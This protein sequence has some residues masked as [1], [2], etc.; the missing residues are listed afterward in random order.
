MSFTKDLNPNQREAVENFDGPS[1]ILSGAGSGKT[2]VL[3]YRIANMIE[4]GVRPWN[5]LAVTFTNKAAKEM[6]ERLEKLIGTH[7]RD[8]WAGTFHSIFARILRK[9]GHLL[10]YNRNFNIYDTTDAKAIVKSIITERL[11][12]DL[13]KFH[14]NPVYSQISKAKNSLLTPS[15]YEESMPSNFF[16]R[17]V[18]DVYNFYQKQLQLN[19]AMDFD[20]LISLP[21][22][23][24]ESNPQVLEAYQNK[25]HYILVD[26][27]QDTNHA[28]YKL[29]NM[30]ADAHRNLCVIGDDDQSIYSFRGATIENILNFEKDYAEA[31]VFKLEQNYRSTK[32]ILKAAADVVKN[33]FERKEKEIW[34]D[35]DD[36]E[37]ISLIEAYD[38]RDEARRI[39]SSIT[40]EISANRRTLNEFALLYRTN[41]QSRVLEEAL[42]KNGLKYKIFG[43][44]KFYD[45]KEIKD[46]LAYL[47]VLVNPQDSQNLK[48]IIN[49]PSRKIG[50]TT[51]EKLEGYSVSQ[52]MTLFEVCGIVEKLG[53]L[54]SRSINPIKK[55]HYEISELISLQQQNLPLNELVRNV[56]EKFGLL[57][58]YEDEASDE[59][60]VK[61][62]NVREL[63]GGIDEF[64]SER[65]DNSLTVFLEEVSLITDLDKD[66]PNSEA[67]TLMT[68]HSAKGLEFPT[69]FVSGLEDG[70][71]PIIDLYENEEKGIEE[72]GRLFYVAVTRA[73]EKLYVSFA[74]YRRR[75][76]GYGESTVKSRFLNE[77]SEDLMDGNVKSVK[78]YYSS[79]GDF[80]GEPKPKQNASVPQY[81]KKY[82]SPFSS[83]K[84]SQ[85]YT[86]GMDVKHEIF[87]K[88]R[89]V[90][91]SGSGGES[92]ISISFD[93]VGVKKLV[94]RFAKL[95][96]V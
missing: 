2:R 94:Q 52:E 89:I 78:N 36:G 39:L 77:I 58:I 31:Q 35:N 7:A 88:G 90:E 33:N 48:R 85:T 30:L 6:V 80:Y 50:K 65:E 82:S 81:E 92:K 15:D 32:N 12:L 67:I 23:L 4:K 84:K 9:D 74:N 41:A 60:L 49:F 71:F 63:I 18:A 76:S 72:E 5:I 86:V 38:E 43:G 13:K 3:T 64:V 16:Y 22:R 70:L 11:N 40:H 24:F 34:T 73:E 91:I 20:D 27:Y 14:P 46:V 56:I 17:N 21:V 62:D 69:V 45:R 26:E 44:L 28:Q 96:I 95:E 75:Y 55:F 54:T 83:Q 8:V 53:S 47:K 79:G 61:A 1:L 87:G 59:A 10:G 29:V 37:K 66:D 93:S 51:I 57:K 19:N 68:V 42:I 25:F